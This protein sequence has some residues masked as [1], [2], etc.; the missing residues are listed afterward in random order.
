MWVTPQGGEQPLASCPL[1]GMHSLHTLVLQQL[2]WSHADVEALVALQRCFHVRACWP[3]QPLSSCKHCHSDYIPDDGTQP[4]SICW[5][6]LMCVST[7]RPLA[8]VSSGQDF[9]QESPA[10]RGAGPKLTCPSDT[11]RDLPYRITARMA[12]SS[13]DEDDM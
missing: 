3:S 6:A 11:E 12:E 7:V 8:P 2:L 1:L 4:K 10:F 5:M 13:D 9:V